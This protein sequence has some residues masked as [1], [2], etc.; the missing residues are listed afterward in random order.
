CQLQ[1]A[2]AASISNVALNIGL[3]GC[4]GLCFQRFGAEGDKYDSD[5]QQEVKEE[6]ATG[7]KQT[8]PPLLQG[9]FFILD[10]WISSLGRKKTANKSAVSRWT[11]CNRLQLCEEPMSKQKVPPAELE[12]YLQSVLKVA[13]VVVIP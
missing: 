6:E 10:I 8:T 2:Y 9:F 7:K 11:F 1:P 5:A 3:D 4:A 13:D 12:R